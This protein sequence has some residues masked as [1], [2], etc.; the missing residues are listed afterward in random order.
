MAVLSRYFEK[1]DVGISKLDHNWKGVYGNIQ[2]ITLVVED[3]DDDDD[4]GYDY[5]P[6]A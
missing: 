6:A 5:A 4:D 3:G 1:Q 2:L